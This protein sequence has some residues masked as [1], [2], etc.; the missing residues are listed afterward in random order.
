MWLMLGMWVRLVSSTLCFGAEMGCSYKGVID[1]GWQRV[2]G[3]R[4]RTRAEV[5]FAWLGQ[6]R[7]YSR[8]VALLIEGVFWLA[9]VVVFAATG[10]CQSVMVVRTT[11]Q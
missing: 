5:S 1:D 4:G 3:F 6:R 8:R 9:P 10:D 7:I 11:K 2:R